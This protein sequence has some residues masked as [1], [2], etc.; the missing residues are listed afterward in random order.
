MRMRRACLGF[1]F[2]MFFHMF[3]HFTFFKSLKA[4]ETKRVENGEV[5]SE[6][7][8][9]CGSFEKKK[10]WRRKFNQR[11]NNSESSSTNAS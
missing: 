11:A 3:N 6:D 2:F 7:N 9:F 5:L 8:G 10:N 1:I 4:L